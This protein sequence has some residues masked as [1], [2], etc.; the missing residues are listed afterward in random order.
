MNLHLYFCP[1]TCSF[2]PHVSLELV[3]EAYGQNFEASLINLGKG[4]QLTPEYKLI[5]A[6]GQVPVL[7]ADGSSLTQVIAIVNYLHEQFPNAKI[8]PS[9]PIQKAHAISMLAW[10]NNTVHTTFTRVFRPE[11]FSDASS[12]DAVK[13]VALETYKSYLAEIENI[14]SKGQTFICGDQLTP[15]DI[16]ALTFIRWAGLAKIDQ[17]TYPNYYKYAE[18]LAEIPSVKNI[19]AKEGI[20]LKTGR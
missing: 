12:K 4:E 2:V 17:Q 3:K 10:M 7:V 6:Q 15:A 14:L 8:F 20:F 5:N 13:M 11:R 9:D 18:R 1:G 19:M 16:Y